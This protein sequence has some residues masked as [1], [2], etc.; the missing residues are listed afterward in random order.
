MANLTEKNMNMENKNILKI[1]G[2]K[3][4]V[5][6]GQE[7]LYR[8]VLADKWIDGCRV[9]VENGEVKTLFSEAILKD[10]F[11]SIKTSH[12]ILIEENNKRYALDGEY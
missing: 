10:G 6:V 1:N 4:P 3:V 2:C 5:P 8:E 7:N 9:Y 11:M 12:D